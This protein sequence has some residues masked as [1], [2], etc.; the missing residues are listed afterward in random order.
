[1]KLTRRTF[2][3]HTT[4]TLGGALLGA[5]LPP[6]HAAPPA[7]PIQNPKS[8][9][10]NPFDPLELIP[11]G[12]TKIKTT[13]LCLGTGTR[14]TRR[15]SDQTRLGPEKFAALIRGA[16]E[17][18]IRA[19]DL[20]D[21]YG[22]HTQFAAAMKG[23]PRDRYTI[24]TKIWFRPRGLPEPERP[25]IPT[26]IA[27][28]LKEL[29][30]D[31]LDAVQLHCVDT[32]AWNTDLRPQM[33]AL[34]ALKQKH[35]IHAHGVSCHSLAALQTAAADPWCDTVHARINPYGL[36]M[37][38]P[39]E[40]VTPVL[41]QLHDSGKAVIGMKI[42][43]V[44]KITDTPEKIDTSLRYALNLGTV[45]ILNIGCLTLAELDDTAT[46]IRQTPRA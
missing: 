30:T 14:G 21:L 1:M 43:A 35:I 27:R 11:L 16:H 28:F 26:V 45:D 13:R 40:T 37:D 34:A 2:L 22:T 25:D 12:K 44:G 8:K 31:Y 32:P 15:Q 36:S 3:K 10:Q 7:P 29:D 33:D 41:K 19:F 38:A 9:I 4:L 20:A 18:G 23:I 24:F 39:P 46:R 42:M 17:R 5:K 6:L